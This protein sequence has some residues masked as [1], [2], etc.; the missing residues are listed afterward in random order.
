MLIDK[1][2][3][4]NH[5]LRNYIEY[6]EHATE[7]PLNFHIWS[8]L[9][10]AAACL[11]RNGWLKHGIITYYP[12][13]YVILVG[14]A[15][16]RKSTSLSLVRKLVL[17]ACPALRLAPSD[18]AGQRQGLLSAMSD[19]NDE[20]KDL[21]YSMENIMSIDL[22]EIGAVKY[23]NMFI[24]ASELAVFIGQKSFEL[25]TCLTDLWDNKKDYSY[26]LKNSKFTIDKPTLT[27]LSATT[28]ESMFSALPSNSVENGFLTRV[29]LV[30]GAAT[31]RRI[32][33][34]K[35]PDNQLR[36]KLLTGFRNC[37]E[38]NDRAFYEDDNAA[39]A[40]DAIY[41]DYKIGISDTRFINYK[42]RRHEH[43][44]KICMSLAALEGRDNIMLR[45]VEDAQHILSVT[46]MAMPNALGEYGMNPVSIARQR[47]M[48]YFLTNKPVDP[49]PE[50]ELFGLLSRDVSMSNFSASIM[51]LVQSGKLLRQRITEAG[52][53]RTYWVY[54][55]VQGLSKED[56]EKLQKRMNMSEKKNNKPKDDGTEYM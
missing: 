19:E 52:S 30:Y 3:I 15:G 32:A 6:V 41:M 2:R 21:A 17:E 20:E 38:R 4:Q 8:A 18:T 11:S 43:L 48:D 53:K 27:M 46:E 36:A 33:R 24:C 39:V 13:M 51:Q 22:D 10:G 23:N 47:I 56:R 5:F 49:V 50:A 45:D 28:A 55:L 29:I 42:S 14:P 31:S 54:M 34:P 9:A 40:L 7:A 1:T 26:R 44:I 25:I 37:F 16:V 35:S 12:N